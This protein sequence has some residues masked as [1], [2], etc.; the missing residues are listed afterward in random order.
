MPT[1]DIIITHNTRVKSPTP[2][3]RPPTNPFQTNHQ[4]RRTRL[5]RGSTC[6]QFYVFGEKK[7]KETK[8]WNKKEIMR[9][10]KE[11]ERERERERE[12]RD[13]T[14][15]CNQQKTSKKRTLTL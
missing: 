8:K 5:S 7:K 14:P 13:E 1:I 4:I 15:R 10:W 2:I 3:F 11:R 6:H 9:R 12:M